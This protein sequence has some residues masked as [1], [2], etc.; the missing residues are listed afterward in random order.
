MLR[1]LSFLSLFVILLIQVTPVHAQASTPS[2]PTPASDLPP[3]VEISNPDIG[4]ALQGV[5]A[6]TGN[7]AIPEFKNSELSFAYSNDPTGTWFLIGENQEPIENG[8]LA[9]WD[10][11]TI[12]DGDYQLRLVVYLASGQQH[13]ASVAGL[14]VRNYSAV[15]TETPT[16]SPTPKP[17][18]TP[19][20][21]STSTPTLTPIPPTATAVPPNPAILEPH[22]LY[23]N[24]ARGALAVIGFFS[25]IGFYRSLQ[26]L[27][28]KRSRR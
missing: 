3:A 28:K 2:S 17:G 22:D 14:R 9:H 13:I 26:S 1:R 8:V 15:E 11:T 6:V 18:N 21:T 25:L 5:V 7:S 23:T 12:T 4:Q 10:T 19:E 27:L 20:P 16:P 24:M